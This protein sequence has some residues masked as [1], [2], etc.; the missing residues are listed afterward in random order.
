M[1]GGWVGKILFVDLSSGEVRLR[2]TLAYAQNYLGGRGLAA[3]LAW[4]EIHQASMPMIQ[5]TAS[6]SPPAP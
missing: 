2:E 6:S 5:R 4:E 3:R 1:T